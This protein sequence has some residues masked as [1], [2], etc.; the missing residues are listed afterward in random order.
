MDLPADELKTME[1][2]AKDMANDSLINV[3][4]RLQQFRDDW[5]QDFGK[6]NDVYLHRIGLKTYSNFHEVDEN[7]DK[8]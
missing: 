1:D 4:T 8:N 3:E 5:T 7:D 6:M 2:K